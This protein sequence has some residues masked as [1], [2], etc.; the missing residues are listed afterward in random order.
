MTAAT[1][2]SST[3]QRYRDEPLAIRAHVALRT[4]SC[5]FAHVLAELPERG[6]ILDYGCGH[7]V[8]SGMA[9]SDRH[10]R[11]DREVVGVDIDER[12]IAVAQRHAPA[13]TTFRAIAPGE[14]PEGPWDA[15][16]LLDVL[17]LIPPDEQ[18]ALLQSL[19][20]ELAPG[21]VLLVKEMHEDAPLKAR[22]M[23]FQERVMV[24]MLGVTKGGT[25]AFTDPDHLG[26]ALRDAGLV[27]TDRRIDRWYPYP[28]HLLI[29]RR[30]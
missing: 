8:F 15:I 22:W 16:V 29:A 26:R 7:G 12:K 1:A 20:R 9:A 23:K 13:G 3:V 2:V 27:V 25:L 18:R 14:V 28:H 6:R 24:K 4:L 30:A 17:Y 19:A 21:G 11:P 10:D 5:P